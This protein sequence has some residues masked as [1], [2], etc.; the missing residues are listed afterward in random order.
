MPDPEKKFRTHIAEPRWQQV[1]SVIVVLA[2]AARVVVSS[3]V[4]LG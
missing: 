2:L 4:S 1:V 3:A